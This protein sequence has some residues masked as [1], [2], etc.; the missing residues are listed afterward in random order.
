MATVTRKELPDQP[1]FTDAPAAVLEIQP[2]IQLTA[3]DSQIF[4]D[5]MEADEE[6][7]EALRLAAAEYQQTINRRT[8]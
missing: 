2:L 3:R 6:P 5:L 4:A 8:L 1:L 7:V